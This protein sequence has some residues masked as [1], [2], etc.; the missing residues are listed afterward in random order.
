MRMLALAALFLFTTAAGAVAA[1]VGH[2]TTAQNDGNIVASNS[3]SDGTPM[4]KIPPKD[5]QQGG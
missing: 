4:T 1:C 3:Q 2:E 5:Q